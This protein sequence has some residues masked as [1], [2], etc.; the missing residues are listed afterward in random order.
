M[1]YGERELTVDQWSRLDSIEQKEWNKLCSS[2]WYLAEISERVKKAVIS[3][4]PFKMY[5]LVSTG[6]IVAI[7]KYEE[8]KNDDQEPITVTVVAHPDYN[9]DLKVAAQGMFG[10]PL[11]ELHEIGLRCVMRA[12]KQIEKA[13][14]TGQLIEGR[15]RLVDPRKRHEVKPNA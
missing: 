2:K 8:K 10:V 1:S 4:P 12:Q 9:A 6:H 5:R 15:K 14:A 7:T 13:K 3:K 11:H